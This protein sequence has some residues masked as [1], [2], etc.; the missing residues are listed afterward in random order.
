M[1][2]VL[3]SIKNIV[4]SFIGRALDLGMVNVGIGYLEIKVLGG[5]A[6]WATQT[7]CNLSIDGFNMMSCFFF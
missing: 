1:F 7:C 6:S 4:F 5:G 3:I 2:Y